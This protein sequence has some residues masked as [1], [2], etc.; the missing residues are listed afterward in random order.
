MGRAPVVFAILCAAGLPLFAAEGTAPE[1]IVRLVADLAPPDL[2]RFP[3][4]TEAVRVSYLARRPQGLCR[5]SWDF[6]RDGTRGP[7]V[8]RHGD[9]DVLDTTPANVAFPD[10]APAENPE[11]TL[12]ALFAAL[13]QGD[14][15][16]LKRLLGNGDR[17]TLSG[18]GDAAR[19]RA[20][21]LERVLGTSLES[22]GASALPETLGIPAGAGWLELRTRH[23]G[24]REEGPGVFETVVE[25]AIQPSDP[26]AWT[27]MAF[28]PSFTL[29]AGPPLDGTGGPGAPEGLV[30]A[31]LAFAPPDLAAF[32]PNTSEL[33]VRARVRKAG[34]I[35]EIR[36]DFEKAGPGGLFLEG[37]GVR[38]REDPEEGRAFPA[39]APARGP[40]E[41]L[42]GF[43]QALV[44]GTF[45]SAWAFVP[46]REKEK[47]ATRGKGPSDFEREAAED[48]ARQER[49]RGFSTPA[50][51]LASL[52]VLRGDPG[53]LA[54][55]RVGYG[56]A[57]EVKGAKGTMGVAFTL[58]VE[59]P[60]AP[61][62]VVDELETDFDRD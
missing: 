17:E 24:E 16:A 32:P 57:S 25:L 40:L 38:K 42:R 60:D 2:A 31:L 19:R 53:A 44:D 61:H 3:P 51:A 49:H 11:R 13:K 35:Y 22:W 36:C 58:F 20:Q 59:T 27:V 15:P 21:E 45:A 8:P 54:E 50:V 41:S 47:L 52:P 28:E 4:R 18:D 62:W 1:G 33:E 12:R 48:L 39:R 37:F 46:A 14:G 26:G 56:F 10:V 55:L 34:T 23:G 43:A 7:L 29:R 30:N 6:E 5:V 9:V